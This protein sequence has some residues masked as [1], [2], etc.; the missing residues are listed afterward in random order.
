MNVLDVN[1]SRVTL[2]F[3]YKELGIIGRAI[4]VVGDRL[5]GAEYSIRIG[6][7]RV[8]ASQFLEGIREV[9]VQRPTVE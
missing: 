9:L 4:E 8:E 6:A 7:Q 2:S 3:T 1:T 5:S